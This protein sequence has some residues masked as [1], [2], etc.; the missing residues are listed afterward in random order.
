MGIPQQL[1][2]PPT[3]LRNVSAGLVVGNP[4]GSSGTRAKALTSAELKAIVEASGISYLPLAGGTLTGPITG[5]GGLIEQRDGLTAQCF[6]LFETY[7][8]GTNNG[9]LR[10]K[11]TS[12]GHQIGSARASSGSNRAVQLGHFDSSQAFTAGLTIATNGQTTANARM[13]CESTLDIAGSAV[14]LAAG[15]FHR[16][17]RDAGSFRIEYYVNGSL[18]KTHYNYSEGPDTLSFS[19]TSTT[20][21]PTSG[22]GMIRPLVVNVASVSSVGD[23]AGIRLQG[24]SGSVI[25]A[26]ID[27]CAAGS[28]GGDLRLRTAAQGGSASNPTDALIL[29]HNKVA[30]FY[31]AIQPATLTDS[32]A[33]NNSIYYSSTQSKLAYKDSGG[34]VNVLY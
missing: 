18:S 12:S 27:G 9:K 20:Y 14:G 33:P 25:F 7:T 24:V 29:R 3:A 11:A 17:V 21:S 22:S 34:T 32:A 5:T 8:S 23:G 10:F 6:D 13:A 15:Y 26:D 16:L 1:A 31:G 4:V 28:Y 2:F 19:A 30:E